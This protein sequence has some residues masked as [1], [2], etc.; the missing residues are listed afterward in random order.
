MATRSTDQ[1]LEEFVGLLGLLNSDP[2]PDVVI[3]AL[4]RGFL[5]SFDVKLASLHVATPPDGMI[6]TIGTFGMSD[7]ASERFALLDPDAQLPVPHVMRTNRLLAMNPRQLIQQFPGLRPDF[8]DHA[9]LHGEGVEVIFVPVVVD[10]RPA[11]VFGFSGRGCHLDDRTNLLALQGL[12]AALSLWLSQHV[13][14]WSAGVSSVTTDGSHPIALSPR[15]RSILEYVAQGWTNARIG[16][17]LDCSRSTIKHEM[18]R[19]MFALAARSR[20]EAVARA[21]EVGLLPDP[22]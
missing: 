20:S 2:Q 12:A 19:I 13:D 3:T 17:E 7:E 15:Q 6:R 10:S 9:A 5:G 21:R 16:I 18:Q 4:V 8:G 1:I 14:T 22:S 11:A